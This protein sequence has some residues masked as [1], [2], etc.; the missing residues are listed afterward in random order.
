MLDEFRRLALFTSGVAE[1]TRHRAEQIV[2]DM[3]KS[4]EVRRDQAGSL[5]KTVMDLGRINRSEFIEMMRGEIRNQIAALGVATNRDVERLE[6]RVSRLE[7]RARTSSGPS[8]KTTVRK[9]SSSKSTRKS[10][11][12]ASGGSSSGS[13]SGGSKTTVDRAPVPPEDGGGTPGA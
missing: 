12:A 6:R 8:K 3:V 13:R 7:D 4:G 11:S 9:K 2:R 5:V 1:L 10:T